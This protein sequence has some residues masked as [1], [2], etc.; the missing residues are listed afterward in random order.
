M[1]LKKGSAKKNK[2]L[3]F[4]TMANMFYVFQ[5]MTSWAQ[6]FQI[7]NFI[8]FPVSI[9]VMNTQNFRNRIITTSFTFFN[10]VSFLHVFSYGLKIRIPICKFRF[11]DTFFTAINTFFRWASKKFFFTMFTKTFNRTFF[12][13]RFIITFSAAIF[14]NI[15]TRRNMKKIITT[16]ITIGCNLNSGC[17]CLARPRTVF[18]TGKPVL[19][20]INHF[21]AMFALHSF[22]SKGF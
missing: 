5:G 1:P 9:F 11:V 2:N 16:I 3:F 6:N 15:A 10:H 14:C 20:N 4:R 17:Q 12:C 21:F 13:L 19:R 18:K 7:R 8:I 22:A